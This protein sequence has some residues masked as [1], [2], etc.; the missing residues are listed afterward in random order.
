MVTGKKN[1]PIKIG[2][3]SDTH[4]YGYSFDL[5]KICENYFHDVE[6]ILHAGDMVDLRALDAF[7]NKKV[8]AV[9]GNMDSPEVQARFPI[10]KVITVGEFKIGL[11]H[12]AGSGPDIEKRIRKEFTQVDCIVYGHT[13]MPANHVDKGILFFNPGSAC[14][15]HYTKLNSVGILE[16]GENIAGTIIRL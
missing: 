7:Y 12:G 14:E 11:I 1:M 10:K 9:C 2:V 16:V 5:E 4:V 8:E 6:L 15:R 3:V 13:H